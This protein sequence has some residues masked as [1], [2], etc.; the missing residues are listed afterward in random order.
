MAPSIERH[1][2]PQYT[3]ALIPPLTFDVPFKGRKLQI[4]ISKTSNEP[5][6]AP[7]SCTG[8]S[9]SLHIRAEVIPQITEVSARV[10]N[11]NGVVSF[12]G[13]EA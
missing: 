1:T 3:S 11:E 7:V 9:L 6:K 13:S 4:E 12:A 5:A 8:K 10:T 2:T